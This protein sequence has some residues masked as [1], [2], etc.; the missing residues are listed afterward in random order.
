[1][2]ISGKNDKLFLAAGAEA[3]KKDIKNAQISLLDGGHFVLEEKHAEAASI[4]KSYLFRNAVGYHREHTVKSDAFGNTFTEE[5]LTAPVT[6]YH[7]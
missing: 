5:I 6:N 3:F 1:L 7:E 2:V 4:I